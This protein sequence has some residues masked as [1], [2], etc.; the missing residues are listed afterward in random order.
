MSTFVVNKYC[1]MLKT[2]YFLSIQQHFTIALID[3][4]GKKFFEIF[5]FFFL[6]DLISFSSL[7]ICI[8]FCVFIISFFSSPPI[9]LEKIKKNKTRKKKFSIY[10]FMHMCFIHAI[11]YLFIS[12]FLAFNLF[13]WKYSLDMEFV[14][15][16]FSKLQNRF[17]SKQFYLFIFAC[18][19]KKGFDNK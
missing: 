5:C 2:R 9:S 8:L 14:C 12:L 16:F 13:I 17:F 19:C 10:W 4:I 7:C 11:R 18:C 3:S 6:V 15:V 1:I